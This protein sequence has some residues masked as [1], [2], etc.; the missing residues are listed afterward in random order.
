LTIVEWR[1]YP[2]ALFP[3][4]EGEVLDR[5]S[6]ALRMEA[7]RILAAIHCSLIEWPGGPRPEPEG[8]RPLPP[9]T[10]DLIDEDL[11]EWW[12]SIRSRQF[13][14]APT[15]GDYYRRN[16]LCANGKVVGVIDWHEAKVRPL[17]NELASATFE[18]CK[19]DQHVLQFDRAEEFVAAYTAAGGPIPQIEI[20]MLLPFIRLWI[21]DDALFSIAYD[22]D[23]G[24]DY[25]RKQIRAFRELS[26][27]DWAPAGD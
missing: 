1:G 23:S 5:E 24:Q 6:S 8:R 17:V 4:V 27:C 18:L 19:N 15:H 16:L 2:V 11:D 13:M 22:G 21:R 7:A 3:F 12:L 20:K 14:L 9:P 10:T 26:C 25:A